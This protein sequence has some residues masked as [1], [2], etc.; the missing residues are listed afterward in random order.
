MFDELERENL[1]FEA[2]NG[3]IICDIANIKDE[4]TRNDILFLMEELLDIRDNLNSLPRIN[5]IILKLANLHL[6]ET[7]P[8]NIEAGKILICFLDLILIYDT[9]NYELEDIPILHFEDNYAYLCDAIMEYIHKVANYYSCGIIYDTDKEFNEKYDITDI[10]EE[11]TPIIN[12]SLRDSLDLSE[13]FTMFAV[14]HKYITT[15][16]KPIIKGQNHDLLIDHCSYGCNRICNNYYKFIYKIKDG[17][18]DTNYSITIPNDLR[19]RYNINNEIILNI[20]N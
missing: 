1:L 6:F 13:F 11:D 19:I 20:S 18:P 4:E 5:K 2:K 16:S 14:L 9:D 8:V 17:E 7:L 15:N 12:T 3:N 10:D